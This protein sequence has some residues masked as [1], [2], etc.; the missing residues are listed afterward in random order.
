[1][2]KITKVIRINEYKFILFSNDSSAMLVW[3]T[4]L[5]CVKYNCVFAPQRAIV[6]N[7]KFVWSTEI[8]CFRYND[9]S[10]ST[11]LKHCTRNAF[12]GARRRDARTGKSAHITHKSRM[13]KAKHN[14][15]RQNTTSN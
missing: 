5:E 12:A 4:T 14:I 6:L 13:Q 11:A 7:M 15:K 3:S 2:P 1:M 9:Y 10:W 8:S